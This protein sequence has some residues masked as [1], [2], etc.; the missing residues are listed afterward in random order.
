MGIKMGLLS[1]QIPMSELIDRDFVPQTITPALIDA[2]TI[3]GS[4]KKSVICMQNILP[5]FEYKNRMV[6]L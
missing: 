2:A 4:D 6:Y 3:P 5:V 1:K